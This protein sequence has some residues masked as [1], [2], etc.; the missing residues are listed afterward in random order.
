MAQ[1][2]GELFEERTVRTGA[3]A[4]DSIV[5][6]SGIDAGTRIVT[7]GGSYVRLAAHGSE[8]IGHGHVH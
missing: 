3:E 2:E 1:V 5:I 6:E 7:R 8:T 4:G